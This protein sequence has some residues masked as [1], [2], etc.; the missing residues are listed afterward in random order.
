MPCRPS[1][2]HDKCTRSG[3]VEDRRG[4]SLS[5]QRLGVHRW[6]HAC[7]MHAMLAMEVGI[8]G[9]IVDI[10]SAI[11]QQNDAEA[12]HSVHGHGGGLICR[13]YYCSTCLPVVHNALVPGHTW[14]QIA[15][16][17][18]VRMHAHSKRD[19]PGTCCQHCRCAATRYT[20]SQ[21]MKTKNHKSQEVVLMKYQPSYSWTA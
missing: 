6:W 14:N 18:P 21:C 10:F 16:H 1:R 15:L 12:A 19:E 2:S 11:N 4:G 5:M 8:H 9:A 13:L 7:C 20:A 3:N 17:K